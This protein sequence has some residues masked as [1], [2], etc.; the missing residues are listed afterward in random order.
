MNIKGLLY[1]IAIITLLFIIYAIYKYKKFL[2]EIVDVTKQYVLTVKSVK[3]PE[4]K[5]Q[6]FNRSFT[7]F[8]NSY[9][10]VA[11]VPI[12]IDNDGIEELFIGGGEEQEDVLLKY[13]KKK[14]KMINIIDNVNISDTSPT[15]GAVAIDINKDG[16]EDLIVARQ[17]G[18]FIYNN[19]KNGSFI[20]KQ[21]IK[22]K[23]DRVPVSLSIT[24]Y[25]NDGEIDI[26]ISNFIR[27]KYLKNY[28]FHN[29]DHSKSNILLKGE[30]DLNYKDVT[31]KTGTETNANTFT[32]VFSDLDND[33]DPDLIVAQD[34]GKLEF[35]EN[36][37][38]KFIKRNIDT[39]FGFWM[40]IGVGDIDNDGDIDIFSSNIGSFIPKNI[41]KGTKKTGIKKDERLNLE[42]IILRNDGK[43]HFHE[44]KKDD[45]IKKKAFGWGVI[46]R[47]IDFDGDLDL[48]FSQ[49]YIKNP[50]N[51]YMSHY[52][53]VLLNTK[54]GWEND[55]SFPNP[56]FGQTP[57][58]MD[59]DQDNR[60]DLIWLNMK[61]NIKIY[62]NTFKGN[63]INVILPPTVDFI[64]A[65][66][67]LKI[68]NKK[69]MRENVKGGEGFGGG[70]SKIMTFGLGNNK[71]VDKIIVKTMKGK[72]Y[73]KK[74][75]KI[76]TT[77][78]LI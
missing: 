17:N 59:V 29:D 76:N 55:Y 77:L 24:D 20:K 23:K 71:K 53:Q 18:V 42:H 78:T 43:F 30:G 49:N 70:Q 41:P 48:I 51:K 54:K 2:N 38:G 33:N 5:T 46:F 4:I 34:A 64:N 52:S 21:I 22:E 75:P 72:K 15:Y 16:Y 63:F 25:N 6:K 50:F 58:M 26:Y 19:D 36:K 10:Y 56:N 14:K 45:I 74:D 31:K 73:I 3:R 13:D 69:Q 27:S 39:G 28:Q 32:S 12:D 44:D 11:G 1:I 66:V 61:G 62:K 40:G 47:D 57:I 67:Y 68:G 8:K 60:H 7:G 35:Y 9:P 37:K 65:K